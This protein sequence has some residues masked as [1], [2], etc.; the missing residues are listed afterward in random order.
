MRLLVALLLALPLTATAD[1]VG[2]YSGPMQVFSSTCST[3]PS[4]ATVAFVVSKLGRK[5]LALTGNGVDGVR[6][7]SNSSFFVTSSSPLLFSGKTY[8][9]FSYYV[10][11]VSGKTAACTY[12]ENFINPDPFAVCTVIHQGILN[13][14]RPAR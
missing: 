6:K 12:V 7:V 13:F 8:D 9:S 11:N 5:Y 4:D 3:P 14:K 2:R 1:I 10:C